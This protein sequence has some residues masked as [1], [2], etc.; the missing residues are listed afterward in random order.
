MLGIMK[1]IFL[2]SILSLSL[3]AA[4]NIR[5][6]FHQQ[7]LNKCLKYPIVDKY[8]QMMENPSDKYLFFVYQDPAV[9]NGGFGDRMG[10]LLSAFVQALRFNR[11]LIIQSKNGFNELF[12][13]YH[14]TDIKRRF[15]ESE[16]TWKNALKWSKFQEWK[17]KNANYTRHKAQYEYDMTSCVSNT[18]QGFEPEKI[19]ECSIDEPDDVAKI[20]NYPILKVASNRAYL[21]RWLSHPKQLPGVHRDVLRALGMSLR[22]IKQG[23]LFELAGCVYRLVMWPTERL[24]AKVD[25]VY[26]EMLQSVWTRQEALQPSLPVPDHTPDITDTKKSKSKKKKGK[27][28]SKSKGKSVEQVSNTPPPLPLVQRHVL[29]QPSVTLSP[30]PIYQVGIHLRCGDMWSYRGLSLST[31]QVDEHACIHDPN[32]DEEHEK[33]R[34]L[35]A[36]NPV[37]L[38][39]CV[40]TMLLELQVASQGVSK[41]VEVSVDREGEGR[42]LSAGYE[43]VEVAQGLHTRNLTLLVYITSDNIYA[44]EQIRKTV[45]Y[46]GTLTSPQ[47]CHIEYDPS[48]DC[49]AF[50]TAYWFALSLSQLYVTQTFSEY[51]LPTS[52]FSRYAGLYSLSS[53]PSPFRSGRYCGDEVFPTS[54]IAWRDQGNWVCKL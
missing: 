17:K 34:Y 52:A 43:A 19:T 5:E 33:S 27:K 46:P 51:N 3:V 37:G 2:L 35:V 24:W 15:N 32:N 40:R 36:G 28:A 50:T 23:D 9:L 31:P 29:L 6:K 26:E 38:G 49:Y 53:Y 48:S 7:F 13:P 44:E 39:E 11:T 22:T 45:A 41:Q 20:A 25:E 1:G 10:G 42:T 14:P 18:E 16:Y 30:S 8:I 47:G 21:C 4:Q 12:R 54:A